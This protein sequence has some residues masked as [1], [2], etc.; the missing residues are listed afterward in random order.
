MRAPGLNQAEEAG[1]VSPLFQGKEGNL[2]RRQSL[3]PSLASFS[4][5]DSAAS[6]LEA[7]SPRGPHCHRSAQGGPTRTQWPAPPS[8]TS[9]LRGA[10][11]PLGSGPSS[12]WTRH[13]GGVASLRP[14]QEAGLEIPAAPSVPPPRLRPSP[15]QLQ[16]FSRV[17]LCGCVF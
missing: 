14:T 17:V 2:C 5:A 3:A 9:F 7:G 1:R 4:G 13:L 8:T 15:P 6:V 16:S 10:P 12:F 11:S